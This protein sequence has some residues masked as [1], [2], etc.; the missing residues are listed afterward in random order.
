MRLSR[1][2]IAQ[3]VTKIRE[4]AWQ[5]DSHYYFVSNNCA[6]ETEN[7]LRSALSELPSLYGKV[8]NMP[9][10]LRD[11]LRDIGLLDES[12]IRSR[13]AIG[14]YYFQSIYKSGAESYAKLTSIGLAE[15]LDLRPGD[16]LERYLLLSAESRQRVFQGIVRMHPE[17]AE[18]AHVHFLALEILCKARAMQLLQ[19][20][21]LE[22][23]EIV[24]LERLQEVRAKRQP[25]VLAPIGYGVPLES[26]L[27]SEREF[28][29][30]N[31][32]VKK[33]MDELVEVLRPRLQPEIHEYS[34]TQVNM[35]A[36]IAALKE[37][38]KASALRGEVQSA[39][40]P[41]TSP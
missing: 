25:W 14:R 12:V 17:Q 15:G 3:V 30:I 10:M 41:S 20:R 23:G 31:L 11:T 28:A 33:L 4:A 13:D 26:E 32:E 40:T 39:P 5:H 29:A 18:E 22:L 7:L 36:S 16:S 37:F 8:N 38:T 19:K 6:T 1:E 24:E 35:A 2:Q 34:Q 21:S 9:K 27:P